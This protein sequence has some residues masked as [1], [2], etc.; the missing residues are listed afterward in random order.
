[1]VKM[2]LKDTYFALLIK[3]KD[4]KCLR[5]QWEGETYELTCLP[6]VLLAGPRVFTK[7][8][9]TVVAWM[10]QCGCWMITYIEDNLLLGTRP[11]SRQFVTRYKTRV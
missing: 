5:L 11:G 4:Q 8:V 6:F 10:R 7:I 9:K 2:D 3:Q 1:M